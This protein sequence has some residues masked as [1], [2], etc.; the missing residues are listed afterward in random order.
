MKVAFPLRFTPEAGQ[1]GIYNVQ[2]IGPLSG[3]ITYGGSID[4]A[5]ANAREALSGYPAALLDVGQ[6]IPRPGEADGK[7]ILWI[8]PLAEVVTPILLRWLRE[9]QGVTQAELVARLG[10]SQQA[11]QKIE[12]PNGNPSLKTRAKVARA[13]G[14]E[15]EIAM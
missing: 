7:D 5:T 6:A 11:V 3:V 13:L 2:G 1:P 12:R 15:I 9:D 10:V 8:A 14:R 4:E